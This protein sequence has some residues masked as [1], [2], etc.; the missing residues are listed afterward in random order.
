MARKAA[1][2]AS[3]CPRNFGGDLPSQEFE[4]ARNMH[5]AAV[6]YVYEP[7]LASCSSGSTRKV[8]W[9]TTPANNL[10]DNYVFLIP[11]AADEHTVFLETIIPS[12]NATKQY[13]SEESGD[14]P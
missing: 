14:E 11:F 12:R 7:T 4:F 5:G 3:V 1:G 6:Q 9:R 8:R 10:R 2:H 13:I